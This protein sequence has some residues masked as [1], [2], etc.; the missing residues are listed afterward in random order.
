MTTEISTQSQPTPRNFRRHIFLAAL[1]QCIAQAGPQAHPLD[2]V[3]AA[4]AYA[5]AALYA[6]DEDTSEAW[7]VQEDDGDDDDDVSLCEGADTTVEPSHTAEPNQAV[8]P[9][10]PTLAQ[11][12]PAHAEKLQEEAYQRGAGMKVQLGAALAMFTMPAITTL[13]TE[14]PEQC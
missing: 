1:P 12:D 2:A 8:R 10:W 7:P 3:R 5:D 4:Y 6:E 9:Q 13:L 11:E 14:S